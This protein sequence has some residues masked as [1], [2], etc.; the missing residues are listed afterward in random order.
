MLNA[1]PSLAEAYRRS[2]AEGVPVLSDLYRRL[3]LEQFV[4]SRLKAQAGDGGRRR[5]TEDPERRGR[6][7]PISG[8]V[9][10]LS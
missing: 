4:A 9:G 8:K 7:R 10:A 5:A 1:P 2:S 3:I 6:N